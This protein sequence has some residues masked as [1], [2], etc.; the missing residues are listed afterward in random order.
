MSLR[1]ISYLSLQNEIQKA[2]EEGI[3][4]IREDSCSVLFSSSFPK[5]I[6]KKMP[7]KTTGFYQKIMTSLE[8]YSENL[9]EMTL[10][11]KLEET[12]FVE[13]G[14]SKMAPRPFLRPSI[15]KNKSLISSLLKASVTKTFST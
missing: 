12:S 6:Q 8:I 13:Y 2:L 7:R 10:E 14:T 9:T 3:E 4:K 5:Q 11:S 15:E 1:P